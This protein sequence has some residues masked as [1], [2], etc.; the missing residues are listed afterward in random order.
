MVRAIG[1][2]A[3]SKYEDPAV[4]VVDD[5]GR[6]VI[7]LLAGHEG[8]ANDLAEQIAAET[9]GQAVVTTGT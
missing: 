4:V 9:R 6:F 8:G 3:A 1:P 7:S 2:H 5:A